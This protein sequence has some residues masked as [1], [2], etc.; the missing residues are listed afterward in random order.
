MS[1]KIILNY[2][3]DTVIFEKYEYYIYHISTL[4]ITV[5]QQIT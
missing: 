4:L 5:S 1:G 2:R 3:Y